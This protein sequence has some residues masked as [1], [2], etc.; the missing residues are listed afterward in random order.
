MNGC[1]LARSHDA[2]NRLA[3]AIN[4]ASTARDQA[5]QMP[6]GQTCEIIDDAEAAIE[7]LRCWD[8]DLTE[9]LRKSAS[10]APCLARQSRADPLRVSADTIDVIRRSEAS[11]SS[12]PEGDPERD[13]TRRRAA[14]VRSSQAPRRSGES[15]SPTTPRVRS[16][17]QYVGRLTS[18]RDRIAAVGGE[19]ETLSRR[20]RAR[21]FAIVPPPCDSSREYPP[22][23]D[24]RGIGM[25]R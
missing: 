6:C 19:L 18:M 15:R 11:S 25:R 23:T 20:D 12:A 17:E 13:Q 7:E 16:R 4:Q 3:V 24:A 22:R 2:P 1:D 9:E 14:R 5:G 8:T 21:A 10:W